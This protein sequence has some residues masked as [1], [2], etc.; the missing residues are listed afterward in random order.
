MIFLA[1]RF[2]THVINIEIIY[3]RVKALV[4]NRQFFTPREVT[5]PVVVKWFP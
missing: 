4:V 3:R 1:L 2:V 5:K